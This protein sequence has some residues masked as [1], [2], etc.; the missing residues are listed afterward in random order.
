MRHCSS[1]LAEQEAGWHLHFPAGR[2]STFL[3]LSLCC[4]D[5]CWGCIPQRFLSSPSALL[6]HVSVAP[7]CCA[8]QGSPV[9]GAA[10][11][12]RAGIAV[13][14]GGGRALQ[15]KFV[16]PVVGLGGLTE[17]HNL[18]AL[19]PAQSCLSCHHGA[20]AHDIPTVTLGD[21]LP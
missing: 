18:L 13:D 16:A 8:L 1:F 14:A 6:T 17:C 15:S 21:Y 4:C 10:E 7:S 3:L 20:I 5:S 2:A 9:A 12:A 19:C 11:L